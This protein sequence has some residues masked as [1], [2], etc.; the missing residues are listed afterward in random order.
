MGL[1]VWDKNKL[2]IRPCGVMLFRFGLC[3][4]RGSVMGEIDDEV[5]EEEVGKGSGFVDWRKREGVEK[6][7]VDFLDSLAPNPRK[8]EECRPRPGS[9]FWEKLEMIEEEIERVQM[10]KFE[11]EGRMERARMERE[12]G[13]EGVL[14]SQVY[15]KICFELVRKYQV[16][17]LEG[18]FYLKECRF[19]V[20]SRSQGEGLGGV[21]EVLIRKVVADVLGFQR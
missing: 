12:V 16:E 8:E 1:L 9:A 6:G 14:E 20:V 13:H 15:G 7:V 5:E 10:A 2:S 11:I 18:W 3:Q 21:V 19:G 4:E 17:F